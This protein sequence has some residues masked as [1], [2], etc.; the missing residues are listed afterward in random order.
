MK[1]TL[2]QSK[3]TKHDLSNP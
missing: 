1:L 2:K 3:A